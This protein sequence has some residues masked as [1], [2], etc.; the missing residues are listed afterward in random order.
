V[1]DRRIVID[2]NILV[3]AVLGVRVR[4]LILAYGREISFF[5]PVFAFDEAYRHLPALAVKRGMDPQVFLD[6]LGAL[7]VLVD[8]VTPE[9]TDALKDAAL[10]RI[11]GRDPNDWPFVAAA[12]ALTCPVW[13]EDNDFFGTGVPTWTTA[14]VEIYLRGE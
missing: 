12:L 1:N 4:E 7:R 2:A 5:T 10:A 11:G 3:R 6:A 9:V 13:T 14:T 8:E